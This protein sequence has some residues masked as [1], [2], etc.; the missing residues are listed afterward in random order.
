M[1]KR[2][3]L[4]QRRWLLLLPLGGFLSALCVMVPALGFLQWVAM[5]PALCYLMRRIEQGNIRL[6]RLYGIGFLYFYAY[7]LTHWFWFV[8]LY[9]LDFVGFSPDVAVFAIAFCWFGLALLQA[10]LASLMLPIAGALFRTSFFEKRQYLFPFL[11]AG[12]YA[13]VEWGQTLTWMGV[14]WGRLALGQVDCGVFFNAAALFGP[15]AIA[16]FIVA[17]NGCIAYALLHT[18][19]IRLMAI[20]GAAVF[21]FHLTAGIVGYALAQSGDQAP[22]RVVAV[23]ANL[24]SRERADEDPYTVYREYVRDAAESGADIVLLPETFIA[25]S[26]TEKNKLG[27]AV[28]SWADTYN[29]TLICG[30]FYNNNG[31]RYNALFTVHPDGTISEQVYCKQRLVP[32][33]E[34]VPMRAFI[35]TVIPP[36][37]EIG[38][39][40]SGDLTP[41]E[42]SGI[43]DTE[44]GKVGS[45]ICFDSIYETLTLD[46]VRDG[47]ELICLST[48]DSWFGDSVGVHMH[49]R[50]AQLRAVESGR[51]IVRSAATGISSVIAPDGNV[52]DSQPPLTSGAV[53]ATVYTRTDRT[54]YSY[55]GN[56]FVYLLIAAEAALALLPLVKKLKNRKSKD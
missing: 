20:C 30:A 14:P 36:L 42:D 52:I 43:M 32:F 1:K 16:F 33:G 25:T 46:A 9:P 48:N 47:A 38:M 55:I 41:G 40:S 54:L 4:S 28:S 35:Q 5:V 15:Y 39:L 27:K 21:G 18:D 19:R 22:V 3:D 7:Y 45:L 29:V 13:L 31:N 37:A 44:H 2:F 34:F 6:R 8:S 56:T 17:V 12:A 50:Q 23:Q 11:Y 53:S 24:G 26:I 49:H 51:Y 10:L